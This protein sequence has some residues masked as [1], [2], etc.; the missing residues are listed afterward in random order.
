MEEKE[1]GWVRY[2]S[3]LRLLPDKPL[4]SNLLKHL[5][6]TDSAGVMGKITQID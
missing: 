6:T 2:I 5:E 4:F 3:V 1:D